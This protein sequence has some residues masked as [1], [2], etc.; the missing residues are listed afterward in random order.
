M[1]NPLYDMLGNSL[2]F[3]M[4]DFMKRFNQF[5]QSYHGD[6]RSQVQ[7]MLNSGQI[8]QDQFNRA[9]QMATQIQ[10]MMK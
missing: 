4:A 2:P 9:S 5:R 10:R 1:S 7:Q 3:P 8:T 6:P